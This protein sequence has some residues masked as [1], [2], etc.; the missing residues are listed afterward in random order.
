MIG[1][2]LWNAPYQ[3][4]AGNLT[5]RHPVL[6]TVFCLVVEYPFA[7]QRS[8][9]VATEGRGAVT[10]ANALKETPTKRAGDAPAE[11]DTHPVAQLHVS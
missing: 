5:W 1:Q 2:R 4:E 10:P 7:Y 6:D 9:V 8:M 11:K 3:Q